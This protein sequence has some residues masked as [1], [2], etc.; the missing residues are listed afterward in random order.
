ML[1]FEK[2][3]PRAIAACL[4]AMVAVGGAL[5][6]FVSV[7]QAAGTGMPMMKGLKN[8]TELATLVDRSLKS[9]PTGKKLLDSARCKKD[10]SCATAH[11]YFQGIQRAHPSAKL[12]NIAE[13]PR[14]LR[15]LV[16]QP[17]P[18]G[19]W[20][21]SRMLVRGEKHT[22]DH[23]GWKRAFFKGEFVWDDPNTGEHILAGDCGNIVAPRPIKPEVPPEK[24]VVTCAKVHI[25]VP[26]GIARTVRFTLIRH[27][28]VP[29][30]N[31][32]GVIEREWRTGSPNNCDWCEWTTDGVFEMKRRYGGDFGFFHTSI[33]TMHPDAGATEVTLVLPLVAR[34]GGVAVCIEIDGVI[35]PAYLV[36]PNSWH[37]TEY[38]IPESF[39]RTAQLPGSEVR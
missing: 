24:M 32:W 17:A 2:W 9:D 39:F 13:L 26:A 10:G 19:E 1:S 23:A 36:L 8:P 27:A 16:K 18:A 7:A 12:G 35:V 14:Y 37:G 34:E 31:C 29:D 5:I 22:Y 4:L 20:Y 25:T 21:M 28:A 15:S 11:D 33:Y 3:Y 30:F 6:L 38:R